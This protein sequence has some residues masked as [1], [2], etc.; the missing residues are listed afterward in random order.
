MS[1][2]WIVTLNGSLVAFR[3]DC[4]EHVAE[5]VGAW[6]VESGRGNQWQ[7]NLRPVESPNGRLERLDRPSR[8]RPSAAAP[9]AE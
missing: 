9:V 8:R 4:R 7:R 5:L 3:T 1:S 6:D 2:A